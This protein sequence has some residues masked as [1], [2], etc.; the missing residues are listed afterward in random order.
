MSWALSDTYI[1]KQLV[2]QTVVRSAPLGRAELYQC[3]VVAD[4]C[5]DRTAGVARGAGADVMERRDRERFGKG[6][7][8]AWALPR[9]LAR[10]ADAIVVLDADCLP[11]P[12]FLSELDRGI[13][14]GA[15]AVQAKVVISNPDSSPTSYLAALGNCLENDFFYASKERLGLAVFL[16]GTG[17]AFR[18]E[19]LERLPWSATSAVEDHEYTIQLLRRGERVRFLENTTVDCPG[20]D[21]TK[22]IGIQRRRWANSLRGSIA[23]AA[24][25]TIAAIRKRSVLLVDAALTQLV[26][27]RPLVLGEWAL[28]A[29]ASIVW[30]RIAPGPSPR[31]ALAICAMIAASHAFLIALGAVRL[32]IS[33]H[34]LKLLAQA[35]PAGLGLVVATGRGMLGRRAG[36][37]A[38]RRS[39]TV[40]AGP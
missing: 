13:A 22:A 27:S 17:M 15:S 23:I 32:G 36:W 25:L 5:S 33:R 9:I 40:G 7:A 20:L 24:R 31:I 35:F 26:L 1:R 10:Y 16:R 3:V 30:A 28:A 11:R 6:H 14:S 21:S 4:N 38:T 18:R 34:R 2:R 37:L 39:K 19:M 8:L 29:A 12:N